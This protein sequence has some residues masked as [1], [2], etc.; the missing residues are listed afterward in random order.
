MWPLLS[1]AWHIPSTYYR[2]L[3]DSGL[4]SVSHSVPNLVYPGFYKILFKMQSDRKIFLPSLNACDDGGFLWISH[5]SGR[6]PC[7]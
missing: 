3:P 1:G 2:R 4:V 6:E 7:T 5:M